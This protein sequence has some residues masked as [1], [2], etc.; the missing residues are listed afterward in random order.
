[1]PAK[2]KFSREEVIK[3][4]FAIVRE[5]GIEKVSARTIANRLKSSPQPIY[6]HF[7]SMEELQDLMIQMARDVAD[8]YPKI[9]YYRAPKR[10]APKVKYHT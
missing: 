4:A 6:S 9:K 3:T 10:N 8:D 7:S 2:P 5:A 1:M